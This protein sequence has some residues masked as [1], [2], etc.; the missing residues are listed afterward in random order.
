MP[1][2]FRPDQLAEHV[3][4]PA[5]A[6]HVS[7]KVL[8]VGWRTLQNP[9]TVEG[10]IVDG[11]TDPDGD[12]CFNLSCPPNLNVH[13][14]VDPTDLARLRQKLLAR[15]IGEKVIV[16]GVLVAD[17]GHGTLEIHPVTDLGPA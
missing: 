15:W 2:L 10:W 8:G 9:A 17:L 7:R 6:W 4:W 12:T 14:E 13:C 11:R 3:S 1:P 5:R 16:T